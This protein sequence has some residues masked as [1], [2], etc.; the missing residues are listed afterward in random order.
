MHHQKKKL[1]GNLD[2]PEKGT[3]CDVFF[4][5]GKERLMFRWGIIFLVI[6]LIAAALGFG[7]LAGTAAWAAKIVFV[8]GI[9]LF[10]VS[11]FTGRRRP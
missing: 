9:I 8:V 4:H 2:E 3:G 11:L 10:L 6:A 7:S 5:Y 1:T